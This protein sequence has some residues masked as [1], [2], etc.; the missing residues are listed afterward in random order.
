MMELRAWNYALM[1]LIPDQTGVPH[2]ALGMVKPLI[3]TSTALRNGVA[4]KADVRI[5]QWD[6][7]FSVLHPI[8]AGTHAIEVASAGG[9]RWKAHIAESPVTVGQLPLT[10]NC[11][12][13]VNRRLL[14]SFTTG[15][16]PQYGPIRVSVMRRG[17]K[18]ATMGYQAHVSQPKCIS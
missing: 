5:T 13:T 16:D 4:L 14:L 2:A 7:A 17:A 9:Q 12:L 6:F 18:E 3:V 1:C 8:T 10:V 15:D 11:P